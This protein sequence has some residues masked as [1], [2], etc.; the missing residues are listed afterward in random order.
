MRNTMDLN[1]AAPCISQIAPPVAHK[2]ETDLNWPIQ[3]LLVED[4]AEAA[5]LV[6]AC[7][8][9][10][11]GEQFRVEWVQ[12]LLQG[13]NR[14]RQPGVELI[15]L[16]LGLPELNGYKSFRA[17]DAAADGKL[18]IVIL[19]SDNRPASKGLTLGFGA[20]DYL[21]KDRISPVQL[22]AALINAIRQGRPQMN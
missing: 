12:T 7:L 13:M 6:E 21:I 14:L 16:D 10:L 20:S 15:L 19:T 1:C 2:T 17:I 11:A 18:P 5:W 3:V 22:R 8:L 4:N 9:G